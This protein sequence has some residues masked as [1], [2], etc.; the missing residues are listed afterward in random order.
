MS[1][2]ALKSLWMRSVDFLALKELILYVSAS[3]DGL[4]AGELDEKMR[5]G[6]FSI[7]F[8]QTKKPSR[9]TL[10][11]QRNILKHLGVLELKEGLYK[12]NKQNSDAQRLVRVTDCDF[13]RLSFLERDVFVRL[14][15]NQTDCQRVF[16]SLFDTLPTSFDTLIKSGSKVTWSGNP[17]HPEITPVELKNFTDPEKYRLLKTPDEVN[18]VFYG[19]RHWCRNELGFL[20]EI[21]LEDNGGIGVMYLT[22]LHEEK[23]DT[24]LKK[25]FSGLISPSNE[26]TTITIRNFIFDNAP[27]I[28]I[29]LERLFK[30]I[31]AIQKEQYADVVLIPTSASFAHAGATLKSQADYQL[32][33]YMRD[34]RGRYISHIRFHRELRALWQN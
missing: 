27:K 33:G 7:R 9:S 12:I 3:P 4:K 34:E 22:C 15:V 17:K 16:F 1:T 23:S 18:A 31:L 19:I 8:G 26:W 25:L 10:F 21:F 32:R 13:S 2:N 6:E 24:A 30:S 11:H 20:E 28:G 14:I 5:T 29:T